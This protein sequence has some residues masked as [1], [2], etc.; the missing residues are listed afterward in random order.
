MV[1]RTEIELFGEDWSGE[2]VERP[3]AL[4]NESAEQGADELSI[5][6]WTEEPGAREIGA[7]L[8]AIGNRTVKLVGQY[9]FR[10]DPPRTASTGADQAPR[11]DC[12]LF[13]G[14]VE[15]AAWDTSG[16]AR[17]GFKAGQRLPK[18]A[19]DAI[20]AKYPDVHGLRGRLLE[21]CRQALA[22][23]SLTV[24]ISLLEDEQ[25]GSERG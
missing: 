19:Y 23:G 25:A 10:Y 6:L 7:L 14:G 2:L 4:L 15:V 22:A 11:G 13:K 9:S 8:E 16:K 20:V 1:S 5:F 3:I 24:T 21:N 18:K 12:H 17:H